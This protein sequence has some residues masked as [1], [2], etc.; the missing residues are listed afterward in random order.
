MHSSKNRHGRYPSKRLLLSFCVW[1]IFAHG[2]VQ[3]FQVVSSQIPCNGEKREEIPHSLSSPVT[4]TATTMASSC[5]NHTTGNNL[6]C[7]MSDYLRYEASSI[8]YSMVTD[9]FLGK[10]EMLR[11]AAYHAGEE[12]GNGG[13]PV[14]VSEWA[15]IIEE[16]QA[17]QRQLTEL[18]KGAP[19]SAFFF[20]TKGVTKASMKEKHFEFVIVDAPGLHDVTIRSG[21]DLHAFSQYISNLKSNEAG[22]VFTNLGGDSVLIAPQVMSETEIGAYSHLA[23]FLRGASSSQSLKLWSLVGKTYLNVLNRKQNDHSPVWLS[24]S[25]LGGTFI[26]LSCVSTWLLSVS[27]AFACSLYH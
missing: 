22:A 5:H 18:L 9:G 2:V 3:L 21:T 11:Y 13:R 10:Q 6:R 8:R 7:N 12:D 14:T 1:V 24:T 26:L 27:F 17:S 4:I 15:A 19:Y 16:S 25:G 23:N 20:E